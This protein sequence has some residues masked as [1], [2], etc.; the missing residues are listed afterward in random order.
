M[1]LSEIQLPLPL[2]LVTAPQCNGVTQDCNDTVELSLQLDS[3]LLQNF[4]SNFGQRK[5]AHQRCAKVFC[6]NNML[7][8]Q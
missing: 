2:T 1:A 7:T 8:L 4:Q 3:I 6:T 5:L